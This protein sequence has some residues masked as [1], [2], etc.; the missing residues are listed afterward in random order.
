MN[1]TCKS[2]ENRRAIK[3]RKCIC[4]KVVLRASVSFILKKYVPL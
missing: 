1:M 3:S 2:K 4:S